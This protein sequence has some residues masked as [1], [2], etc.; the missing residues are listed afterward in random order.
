M[1]RSRSTSLLSA[2]CCRSL[3]ALYLL[4][5]AA[6]MGHAMDRVRVETRV[7]EAVAQFGATGRGVL[8]AVIDRGIDWRNNDFRNDDGT[9]RIEYIFDLTDDNGAGAPG[10]T[11][12]MGTIYTRQQMDQALRGGQ[13]PATRDAVGHGTTT[14]GIIAGNGRNL[15]DRK[16]RGIAP[17]AT[18]ISV[19]LVSEGAPAH[20]GEPAEA[21]F[22]STL[23]RF[24]I[25]VDFILD[26]ARELNMPCVMLANFGS[27]QGPT[28]GTSDICRKIDSA[29]GPGKPGLVFVT[30]PGDDGGMP[31]R[32]GGVVQQGRGAAIQIQKGS[33]GP[34]R[35][36]MWYSGSDR[37][38]VSVQTPSGL[39]GPYASP[40]T[41]DA[42]VN[43]D[44]SEFNLAHLGSNSDFFNAANE[45][46]ELLIDFKGP[47]GLYTVTLNGA[48]VSNG[49]FDAIINPSTIFQPFAQSN[50]FL[51][52]VAPGSIWD[53]ATAKHNICPGDYVGRTQ[54]TDID[55]ARRSETDQG[56]VG[57]IWRGSSTGPTF[58]GRL[59]ID[60]C[61]PGNS[62]FTTYN[63]KSYFATFRFNLIQDG[64]GFYGRANAVSAAAPIV[65]GII[66]LMLE[67]NPQLDSANVK[68]ILQ[69]TARSDQFTGQTPNTTW[70]YGKVDAF[71]ALERIAG[72]VTSEPV[73]SSVTFDG[74]KKVVISG[75]KFGSSPR[76]LINGSDRTSFVSS[77]SETSILLKG[78]AKKLG[79]KSGDNTVQ[80]NNA[81]GTSSNAFILRI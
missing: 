1:K 70:G 58:D 49:R 78:K 63:P 53:G 44:E 3:I 76:V 35:F 59:G 68:E 48:T 40:A 51:S 57:E 55:G 29:V 73:I 42:R 62:L 15:P 75:S 30:G 61:A 64:Q 50:R 9:T 71:A 27:Q 46:R 23:A 45:K 56:S 13:A 24:P 6:P 80:V 5:L 22:P 34:M 2:L 31:N 52:F 25:A 21:P 32:A 10:N 37:F 47:A 16:Y 54:W 4:Y 7:D 11:Y 17:G 8:V 43:I 74:K 33:D 72:P 69:Q 67:L 60:V 39:K 19:K 81:S 14:A 65:T 38:D 41:N 79:L 77:S 36:D 66:A 18:I 20:D 28:D 12:G 26:K